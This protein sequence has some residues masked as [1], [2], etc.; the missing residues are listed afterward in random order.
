V[1]LQGSTIGTYQR[2]CE[3]QFLLQPVACEKPR[4]FV[5]RFEEVA[6]KVAGGALVGCRAEGEEQK[7]HIQRYIRLAMRSAVRVYNCCGRASGLHL[8]GADVDELLDL[9]WRNIGATPRIFPPRLRL[10]NG[11]GAIVPVFPCLGGGAR[12]V[13]GPEDVFEERHR[14]A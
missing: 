6:H 13:L 3:A 12:A 1:A 8:L 5:R 9:V 11:R 14:P 2:L 10:C 7:G 4:A